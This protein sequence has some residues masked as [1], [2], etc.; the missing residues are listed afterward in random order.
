M[1]NPK[2]Q[3]LS[4]RPPSSREIP[5]T[6]IQRP[7]TF[8]AKGTGLALVLFSAALT[9]Y[10]QTSSSGTD[11]APYL[12]PPH[13]EMPPTFWELHGTA[14]ILIAGALVAAVVCAVWLALLPRRIK[15]PAPVLVARKE[16]AQLSLRPE[17]G[18]CL[19]AVSQVLRRYFIAAFRLA[20]GEL[21]TSEFSAAMAAKPEIGADLAK[22]VADFLR[23]CDERKFSPAA[24]TEPMGAV[25]KAE[26]FLAQAEARRAASQSPAP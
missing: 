6:N 19:S 26:D 9:I 10:P 2:F 7:W 20:D 24:G 8:K 23:E 11:A 22:P 5:R 25:H 1:K 16:L 3:S 4:S 13:G 14:V 12:A 15:P 21:N 17:D 18:A